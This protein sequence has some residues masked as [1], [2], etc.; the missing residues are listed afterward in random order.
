MGKSSR[1]K[2]TTTVSKKPE[3]QKKKTKDKTS[4]LETLKKKLHGSQFRQL[5]E[6]LY[7]SSGSA[8]FERFSR[9][10]T[11]MDAYHRGFREQTTKWPENPL[12]AIIAGLAK[13]KR[14]IIADMGCG[15]AR[16]AESLPQHEVHSF[17]LV[18]TKPF[19]VPCNIASVPLSDGQCDVV[20]Y[21]LALM[22]TSQWDFL[23]EGHRILKIN[24]RLIVTEVRSRFDEQ[25]GGFQRFETSLNALGFD[26][27]K[28]QS[29]MMFVTFSCVKST[30]SSDLRRHTAFH[31]KPC[32]YKR[33]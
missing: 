33:R 24:G 20:V 29:S 31:L 21:C 28:R 25:Q 16:L 12:D 5:N 7:K 8:N 32:L 6:D 17:D 19:V 13:G 14:K 30:R 10:P 1:K 3:T 2:K 18:R 23:I 15:D 4:P 11:L 22:G 27:Q 9:D 26:V